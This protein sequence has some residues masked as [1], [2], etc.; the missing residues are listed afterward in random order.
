MSNKLAPPER[1]SPRAVSRLRYALGMATVSVVA[2]L[3]GCEVNADSS[4]ATEKREDAGGVVCGLATTAGRSIVCVRGGRAVTIEP[5]VLKT[6]GGAWRSALPPALTGRWRSAT[7][8]DWCLRLWPDGRYVMEVRQ[9]AVDAGTVSLIG[10]RMT[11]LSYTSGDRSDHVWSLVE[12]PNR[13]L[14]LDDSPW[15]P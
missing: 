7:G 8:A 5:D 3:V 9:V 12:Q 15:I 10:D 6:V 4:R 11:F 13:I 2:L 1:R 14:Y